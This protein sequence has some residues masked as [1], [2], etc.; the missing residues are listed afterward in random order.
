MTPAIETDSWTTD[1]TL[2]SCIHGVTAIIEIANHLHYFCIE[3]THLKYTLVICFTGQSSKSKKNKAHLN[4]QHKYKNVA[5][6]IN[7]M[8]LLTLFGSRKTANSYAV[9]SKTSF[10]PYTM[11][12]C[13]QDKLSANTLD[14]FESKLEHHL[15]MLL[16]SDPLPALNQ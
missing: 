5:I 9:Y 14:N 6:T 12:A 16:T 15:W 7:S 10:S 3:V 11:Y 4:S 13:C 2:I 1:T 8:Y